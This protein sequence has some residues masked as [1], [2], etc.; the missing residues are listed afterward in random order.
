MHLQENA[1]LLLIDVQQ[2]FKDPILGRRN[3]PDAEENIARL[4]DVWRQ[5]RRPIVHIQ[6]LSLSPASVFYPGKPGVE[7]QNTA[8]PL[9]GEPVFTKHVNSAFIG[10]DL[11]AYLRGHGHEALII[12]GLTTDHCVSTTTRMAGN[13]GFVTYVVEDA[14]ATFDK[15][16]HDGRHFSAEDVHRISLASLHKEFGTVISTADLLRT[17]DV[18]QS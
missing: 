14:T 16:G 9:I 10:T 12:I 7:F 18:P 5:S 2:G 17:V 13:L 4:L 3:N 6:H 1:V 8:R 15:T 11:E